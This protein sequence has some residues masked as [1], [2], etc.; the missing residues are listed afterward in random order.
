MKLTLPDS[1]ATAEL[2][3]RL[4]EVLPQDYSGWRILLQGELGSG[5]STLARATLHA[6][7][8]EGPV[9]SPTYTLV[10]P[11]DIAGRGS[12]YHVDLYRIG[13]DSELEFLGWTELGEGLVLVEW[14]ERVPALL[15]QADLLVRLDFPG[16]AAVGR[17]ARVCAPSDRGAA[18]LQALSAKARP[19][20]DG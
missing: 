15:E 14:P 20:V 7:G 8:H 13:D 1:A 18:L 6:L 10:E 16:D 5:K 19:G 11:Y 17:E 9:P 4:A 12:V 2:G 3:R